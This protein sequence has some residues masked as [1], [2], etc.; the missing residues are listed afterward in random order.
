[1]QLSADA[2]TGEIVAADLTSNG[3]D[4]GAMAGPLLYPVSLPV[5]SFIGEGAFD[6]DDVYRRATLTQCDKHLQLIAERGRTGWQKTSGYRYHALAE[7]DISR[8]KRV[9]C[10]TLR[11]RTNARQGTEVA[12]A[13]R[14][15]NRMLKP[16][17]GGDSDTLLCLNAIQDPPLE[18][19]HSAKA[20]LDW[21]LNAPSLCP[22]S[23]RHAR[24]RKNSSSGTANQSAR[25]R[26]AASP[27]ES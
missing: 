5:V 22:G 13:V 7:A 15:M 4:D 26:L 18:A 11:W 8:Y 10:D 24:H 9:I 17:I 16:E 23:G 20:K 25:S 12:V 21:T 14:A 27:A 19:A 3:V 6:R 1:L 2:D